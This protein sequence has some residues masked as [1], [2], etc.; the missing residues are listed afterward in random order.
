[1]CGGKFLHSNCSA[2]STC[3]FLT[4]CCCVLLHWQSARWGVGLTD[5][6][7]TDLHFSNLKYV[8]CNMY[9][10]MYY[11][12]MCVYTFCVHCNLH[13]C[14]LC[15]SCTAIDYW[16]CTQHGQYNNTSTNCT[17]FSLQEWLHITNKVHVTANVTHTKS[18]KN[19]EILSVLNMRHCKWKFEV[20]E[21]ENSKI[22]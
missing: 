19:L 22:W 15:L 3:T 14:V 20:Q 7:A 13:V 12:C 21:G 16:T 2:I 11:V 4:I 8:V 10:F 17:Q 18:L 1:M 9:V 5:H 6:I